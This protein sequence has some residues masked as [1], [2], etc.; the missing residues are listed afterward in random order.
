[1]GD[2]SEIRDLFAIPLKLLR[3]PQENRGPQFD[4]QTVVDRIISKRKSISFLKGPYS[5]HY[6]PETCVNSLLRLR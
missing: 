2:L 5:K 4:N 1:M 6:W 3:V